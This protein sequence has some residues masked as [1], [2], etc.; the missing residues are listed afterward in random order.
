MWVPMM[1]YGGS[2]PTVDMCLVQASALHFEAMNESQT[3]YQIPSHSLHLEQ[4]STRMTGQERIFSL[5]AGSLIC[6]KTS[7]GTPVALPRW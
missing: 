2:C 3:V 4:R 1:F 5:T 7:G 6:V